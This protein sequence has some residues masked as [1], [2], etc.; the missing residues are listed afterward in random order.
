M[1]YLLIVK[2]TP[3]SERGE[4]PADVERLMADMGRFNEEMIAAGAW[5]TPPDWR[6]APRAIGCGS[7]A[8]ASRWSR[9]GRS[10]TPPSWP[11]ATGSWS[12]RPPTRRWDGPAACPSPPGG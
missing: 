10:Q 3:E 9:A 11:R 2:A 6:P 12:A 8:W 7:R 4:M 1:R 5:S